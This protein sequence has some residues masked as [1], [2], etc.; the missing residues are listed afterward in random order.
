MLA[1]DYIFETQARCKK[2]LMKSNK[3]LSWQVPV[4]T[5][6]HRETE[7]GGLTESLSTQIVFDMSAACCHGNIIRKAE[8]GRGEAG[9]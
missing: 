9:Q 5:Y 7:E 3:P 8:R 6:T 2:V 4:H 1:L